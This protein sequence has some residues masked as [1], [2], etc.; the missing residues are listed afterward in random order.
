MPKKKPPLSAAEIQL[1]RDWIAAGA[2]DDSN[3]AKPLAS[4]AA[5]NVQPSIAV[6]WDVPVDWNP[7]DQAVVRRF[8]RLQLVP[9]PPKLPDVAVEGGNAIDRF[10]AAKWP[11]DGPTPV[12]CDDATFARRVFLDVIGVIPSAEEAKV[13]IDDKS[14]DKR[15]KLIDALLNRNRDY[16]A[17]WVPFWEDALCSN[18]QHQGGVGTHGNYRQ[19]VLDNSRRTSRTM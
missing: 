16:A 1:F 17:N 15:A 12:L 3:V 5:P 6:T 10:I 13:F 9:P 7:A 18:G 8:L 19:W 14:P 4:A 11:K 2:V